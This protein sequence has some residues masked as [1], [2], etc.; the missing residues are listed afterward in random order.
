MFVTSLD[1]LYISLIIL[2]K[3]QLSYSFP[4]HSI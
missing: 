1:K 2:N 4:I 3:T